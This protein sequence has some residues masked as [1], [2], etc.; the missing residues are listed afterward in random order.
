MITIKKY[1]KSLKNQWNVFVANAINSSFLFQRDFMEYHQDRFE[2]YSLL[3]FKGEKLLAVL[4]ANKVA[5]IVYS[6]QGLSYGGLLI[7][8]LYIQDY[9]DILSAMLQYLNTNKIE[10][11]QLNPIPHIYHKSLS[12]EVAYATFLLKAKRNRSDAYFVVNPRDYDMNRNRKRALKVAMANELIFIES[13]DFAKFW[14]ILTTNLQNR[15]AAN[16]THSLSEISL[17]AKRFP[18]NIK[19]FEVRKELKVLAGAV[20]FLVNDVAHIQYSSADETRE[21]TG[22]MDFLFNEILAYYHDKKWVSFGISGEEQGRFLNKGL[23][24][25]KQSFGASVTVQN[26][27]EIP[28]ANY[29]LLKDVFR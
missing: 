18:E 4:P 14:K 19:L 16:P 20:V 24:Y 28:T 12:E 26:F 21:E 3:A 7:N 11:L 5:K 2:D 25:W 6:H 8:T 1:N 10:Q 15:F 17:L 22:S 9:F 13:L 29:K 27:Y 23:V